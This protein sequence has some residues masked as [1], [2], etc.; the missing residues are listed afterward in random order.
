[1]PLDARCCLAALRSLE[2][3]R[4][5]ELIGI[6]PPSVGLKAAAPALKCFPLKGNPPLLRTV[7]P[8]HAE[9]GAKFVPKGNVIGRASARDLK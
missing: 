5:L 1:M 3:R 4:L 8:S 9:E 2:L 7:E 6:S